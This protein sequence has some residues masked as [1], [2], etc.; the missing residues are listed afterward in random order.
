MQTTDHVL[1]VRPCRFGYNAETAVNNA[2]QKQESQDA[3][4]QIAARAL[5]EFDSYVQLLRDE[6]VIVEVMQDSVAPSTPD[7]IFPNNCVSTHLDRL[8]DGN[9]RRTVV[10]YPMFAENRRK[11]ISKLL[12]GCDSNFEIAIDLGGYESRGLFLEGTGSLI[13][14]RERHIAYACTSP[15]TSEEVVREWARLLGYRYFLFDAAD[16]NGTPIYHTNVM[17]HVGT[18]VAVVC[19]DAISDAAKRSELVSLLEESGKSIVEISLDQ[20]A[21]FA[22]NMLEVRSTSGRKILVMSAAAKASLTAGQLEFL[23]S[24]LKIVSP[25]LTAIETAGGGSAR[26]MLAEVF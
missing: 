9:M 7:S 23:E 17:M 19:L 12:A 20:M 1:M 2:F 26:C 8:P 13:L 4:E 16:S 25:D 22:G 5:E 10:L 18:E 3:A 6:G 21:S 24:R 11:E 14:D 15:R